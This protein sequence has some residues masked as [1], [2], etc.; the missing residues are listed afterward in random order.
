MTEQ[1]RQALLGAVSDELARQGTEVD[2]GAVLRPVEPDGLREVP[3]LGHQRQ[4]AGEFVTVVD[5]LHGRE[6][7]VGDQR[8]VTLAEILHVVLAGD[9]RHMRDGVEEAADVRD[10]AVVD[11]VGPELP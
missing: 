1:G 4:P 8:F 9:E 3:L 2:V 6:Q 11:R 7:R 5:E 10:D